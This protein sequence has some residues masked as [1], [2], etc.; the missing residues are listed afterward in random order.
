MSCKYQEYEIIESTHV[1]AT[2][3]FLSACLPKYLEQND[4]YQFGQFAHFMV[5][6]QTT[7]FLETRC[8]VLYGAVEKLSRKV[9]DKKKINGR[10]VTLRKRVCDFVICHDVPILICSKCMCL[11]NI[12]GK[13]YRGREEEECLGSSDEYKDR[14]DV[15]FYVSCRNKLM[16]ELNFRMD[17][18]AQEYIRIL[19]IFHKMLLRALDYE[20]MF[21]DRYDGWNLRH[22]A[23]TPLKPGPLL[24]D[25][26]Y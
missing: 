8:I 15:G 19:S 2:E 5:E 25:R 14:C 22:H 6:A 12:L 20:Y 3:K 9:N 4:H 16:H 23:S 18:S 21:I 13:E 1:D 7:G 24:I 11:G 26:Q 17:D 10:K